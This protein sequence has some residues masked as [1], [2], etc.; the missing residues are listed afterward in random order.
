MH[1]GR[2]FT[3]YITLNNP[4]WWSSQ[5]IAPFNP[6]N[7]SHLQYLS[8]KPQLSSV[9]YWTTCSCNKW[10][11]TVPWSLWTTM[12]SIE[13]PGGDSRGTDCSAVT[14]RPMAPPG[15]NEGMPWLDFL[16]APLTWSHNLFSISHRFT[17][18]SDVGPSPPP[19]SVSTPRLAV[20]S[21]A[22]YGSWWWLTRTISEGMAE[23]WCLLHWNES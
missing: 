23:N 20:V 7:Y 5:V 21:S 14:L 18:D 19:L 13:L 10:N 2:V 4:H 11:Q 17:N 6:Q 16:S 3:Q 8:Q 15:W 12:G 9:P 22:S 1:S